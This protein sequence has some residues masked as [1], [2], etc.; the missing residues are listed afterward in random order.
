[1]IDRPSPTTVNSAGRDFDYDLD[2]F[3]ESMQTI[4][5]GI[6]GFDG[7]LSDIAY[8]CSSDSGLR[9][10]YSLFLIRDNLKVIEVLNDYFFSLSLFSGKN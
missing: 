9:I 2:V 8:N 1:M 4:Q 10:L 3:F 7:F 5:G 6:G